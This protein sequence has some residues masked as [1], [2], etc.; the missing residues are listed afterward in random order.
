MKL[1]AWHADG[2]GFSFFVIAETEQQATELVRARIQVM[3]QADPNDAH[4]LDTYDWP[5]WHT[6]KTYEVGEVAESPGD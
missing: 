2:H 4:Y 5:R 1:Y 6:L 3:R